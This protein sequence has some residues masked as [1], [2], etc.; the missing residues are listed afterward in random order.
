V[1]LFVRRA[2]AADAGFRLADDQAAEVSGVC[3]RLDG[4][5]LAIELAAPH[6]TT[7]GP[8]GLLQ[9]LSERLAALQIPV[10]HDS[11]ARH[12]TLQA[13][14]DWSHATLGEAERRLLRRL[15]LFRGAFPMESALRLGLAGG[16]LGRDT[17]LEALIGLVSKSM[18][19]VQLLRGQVQYRL[20]ETTRAY[21]LD[22]LRAAGELPVVSDAH[23]E[24]CCERLHLAEEEWQGTPATEWVARHR[25][26]IDDVRAALDWSA[27]GRDLLASVRLVLT[28]VPLFGRLTLLT[29]FLP[30]VRQ[31][32]ER[33]RQEAPDRPELEFRLTTALG[34]LVLFTEGRSEE[35]R[36]GKECRRLCRSRWSPYH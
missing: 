24:D 35:R 32:I 25:V 10:P 21:A 1:Q 4:M 12:Q 19:A 6:A 17:A 15:A 23:A 3:R 31:L 30:R 29:E 2:T 14:L 28:S 20:L 26:L 13:T 7:L 16:G 33:V 22:K 27:T 8:S 36:V 11:R 18:V 34:D 9:R 5:P